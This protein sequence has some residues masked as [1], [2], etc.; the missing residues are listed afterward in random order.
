MSD[1]I[2]INTTNLSISELSE[3]RAAYRA[4][5]NNMSLPESISDIAY[6]AY[7]AFDNALE[8]AIPET[9]EE[10][11]IQCAAL[12]DRPDDWADSGQQVVYENAVKLIN[13][14]EASV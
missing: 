1:T 14:Q 11:L 9:A 13:K 8:A 4:A 7:R 5:Y 10:F 3:G 12:M 6:N 2:H